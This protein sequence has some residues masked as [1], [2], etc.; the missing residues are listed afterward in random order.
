MQAPGHRVNDSTLTARESFQQS[1]PEAHHSNMYIC[2][3]KRQDEEGKGT[4][5]CTV[6]YHEKLTPK[7][8]RYESHCTPL[9]H[10]CLYLVCIHQMAPPLTSNS[11][12][13]I[14]AYYFFIAPKG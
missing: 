6:L 12:H 4:W 5:I 3:G 13:L 10:T 2:I 11:R 9:H 8:L 14:A 7:A 1:E